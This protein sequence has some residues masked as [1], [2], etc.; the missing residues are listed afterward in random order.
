[1]KKT[2]NTTIMA[3][4][5]SAVA[6]TS[7]A[8]TF[9]WQGDVNYGWHNAVNWSDDDANITESTTVP[10]PGDIVHWGSAAARSVSLNGI[11]SVSAV[12]ADTTISGQ[13]PW[14]TGAAGHSLSLSG[15]SYGGLD[16]VVAYNTSGKTLY[17]TVTIDAVVLNG[18]DNVVYANGGIVTF[19]TALTETA[20]A[21]NLEKRGWWNLNITE[22]YGLTGDLTLSQGKI[23]MDADLSLASGALSIGNNVNTYMSIDSAY[24]Y[25]VGELV[26]GGITIDAGVYDVSSSANGV[27]ISDYFSGDG[28]IT[29]IPEPAVLGLVSIFGGGLFVVRRV[30]SI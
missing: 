2:M 23:F 10:G 19:D 17:F 21:A 12:I 3:L 24:T 11:R 16:N 27:A 8:D 4:L 15:T 20:G 6:L 5:A 28:S 9:Y 22:S 13:L 30:F 7:L 18:G 14:I 29:V 26:L 1:M 25:S